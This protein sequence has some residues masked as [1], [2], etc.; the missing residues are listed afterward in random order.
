MIGLAPKQVKEFS[1]WSYITPSERYILVL[2]FIFQ[3]ERLSVALHWD[4]YQIWN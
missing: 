3:I 1:K 4:G 2:V